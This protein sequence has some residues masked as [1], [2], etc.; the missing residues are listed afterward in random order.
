LAS[1]SLSA[2]S[3]VARLTEPARH[4]ISTCLTVVGESLSNV[5]D[6]V[7]GALTATG[8]C[9]NAVLAVGSRV[10]RNATLRVSGLCSQC[11][12]KVHTCVIYLAAKSAHAQTVT[13]ELI[14]SASLQCVDV[15][16]SC[17]STVST[18]CGNLVHSLTRRSAE[19]TLKIAK[20]VGAS[21]A[22]TGSRLSAALATVTS[23]FRR[24]GG[25]DS[26]TSS[27]TI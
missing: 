15:I 7:T 8:T 3:A 16:Q 12:T 10:A 26:S 20:G 1:A 9:V 5:S 11:G 18:T 21:L 23:W 6:K 14:K 19:V 2:S 24:T 17:G 13:M 25:S 22:A 27:S 4:A